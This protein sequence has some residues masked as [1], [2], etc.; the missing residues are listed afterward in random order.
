MSTRPPSSPPPDPG[1]LWVC[2]DTAA[3]LRSLPAGSVDVVATS[4]PYWGRRRYVPGDDRELG[5]QPL[6]EYLTLMGDVFDEVARV[7]APG[8][9]VWIN[10]G[11]AASHSGGSGGDY[12]TGGSYAGRAR[13]KPP[14]ATVWVPEPGALGGV[15]L[16]K[17]PAGQWADVPGRLTHELQARG[18]LLRSNIVWAKPNPK[19]EAIGHV[20]RPKESHERILLLSRDK[21]GDTR[22]DSDDERLG[23][24][25]ELDVARGDEAVG[26]APW[27]VALPAKMLALSGPP[28]VCLDPFAGR[29]NTLLAAA[30]AGWSCVGIDFDADA[31]DEVTARVDGVEHLAV[32]DAARALRP[33]PAAAA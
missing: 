1:L 7:L 12:N 5:I 32:E 23:D 25:W 27:P 21:P 22:F 3:T 26:W 29:G 2:G 17:L 19:R 31:V 24:V 11:D 6:H 4:P 33:S 20:R 30:A 10:I 14:A 15:T 18:W 16:M 13:Y 8:G 28:G 9:L